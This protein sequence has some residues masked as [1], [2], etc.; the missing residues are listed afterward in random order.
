MGLV[1]RWETAGERREE[2]STFLT[3]RGLVY[4][5]EVGVQDLI[6]K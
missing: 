6:F 3:S 4:L 2:R 1:K 5:G